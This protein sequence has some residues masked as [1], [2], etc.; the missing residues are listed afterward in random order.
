MTI[1]IKKTVDEWLDSV[2]YS[3]LNS[4]HYK[5]GKFAL[6]MMNFI[7][8]VNGAEGESNKTPVM[9]L[10]MLDKVEG[11]GSRVVN[12]MFRGAAKTT[13]FMEYL[14]LYLGVFGEI[15]GFGP[16]PSMIYVSDSMDNGVKSAR[17]NIEY[18]WE[19]SEFL[20]E[21]LPRKHQT[22]TDNYIEWNCKSGNRFG[23]KMFGAK[24]GLRGTKIFGKRPRLAVLDDLLSDDDAKSKAAIEA[25]NNTIDKGVDY[26][27]D[28][29]KR[30]I[31]F[32]GTP[33]AKEDPI[34]RA[35]ESG[36]W[37][38]NVWPVCELFPCD[39]TEFRGA[40]DD[41]FTYDFVE[42]QYRL[43]ELGGKLAAFNQEM[44]LRITSSEERLVQDSEIRWYSR[45][46]LLNNR[47]G[48]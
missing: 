13:V 32:N 7:K 27:L 19:T 48:R 3:A 17:K 15:D 12:L 26:A 22:I 8:L 37:S 4:G 24:T 35:V 29:E 38:V 31:I 16:V 39:R 41:R 33:F 40:W 42:E 5:P 2:D 47:G 23:T 44:M 20:Q 36:A 10:A 30:K 45:P 34:Y 46:G 6:K 11:G 9:H 18:R 1:I 28:P 25:I 43:S 14:N 21:W